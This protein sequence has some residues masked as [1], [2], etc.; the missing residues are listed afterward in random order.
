MTRHPATRWVELTRMKLTRYGRREWLTATV[1]AAISILICVLADLPAGVIVILVLWLGF[2]A[3]FRDPVRRVPTERGVW[4]A[5]S[6]GRVTSVEP[7]SQTDD[8]ELLGCDDAIRL[9]IFLSVLDV[10]VNRA[11]CNL[12]VRDS[13]HR[14][15]LYLNAMDPQSGSR[16][17]SNTLVAEADAEFGHTRL[18]VRQIAGLIARRIVCATEPGNAHQ[19]GDPFGMIKFGSRTDVVIP[20]TCGLHFTVQPGDRVRAGVTIIARLDPEPDA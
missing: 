1:V 18:L 19:R 3:F 20:A 13:I 11:P 10:H 9:S 2:A 17:E 16:N 4:V 8:T 15:G 12:T 7:E 6:D 14:D 5:P